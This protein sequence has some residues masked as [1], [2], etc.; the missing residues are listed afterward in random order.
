MTAMI[1]TS[2]KTIDWEA[3]EMKGNIEIKT[4]I[5]PFPK[6]NNLKFHMQNTYNDGTIQKYH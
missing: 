5:L 4:L 2:V 3:A 6:Q 1:S